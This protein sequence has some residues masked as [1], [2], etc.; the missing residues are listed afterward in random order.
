MDS[1]ESAQADQVPSIVAAFLEHKRVLTAY[2]ARHFLQPEDA[3][4]IL[5]DAFMRTLEASNKRSILAPKSYLF[6]TARNLIYRHLRKQARTITR[7]ISEVGEEHL[8]A[9]DVPID[10]QIEDRQKLG[11]FLEAADTLPAQC[12][13]VFLMRK[14][15]GLSHRE[16]SNQLGI[17]TSTVERH[18]SNAIKRCRKI[19]DK[20]G[21]DV[22]YSGRQTMKTTDKGGADD[23]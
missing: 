4:D 23:R 17:S 13:R 10:R 21:F 18:I 9:P 11:A 6:M 7:E 14:L 5:Q 15:Y 8:S 22:D 1:D 12:R 16:I 3:E 2:I 20:Q 19:M